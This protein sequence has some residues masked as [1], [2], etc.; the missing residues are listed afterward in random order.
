MTT[1][2]YLREAIESA[3]R[4]PSPSGVPVG[5]RT[6]PE[7]CYVCAHCVGRI[8]DLGCYLPTPA[9]PIWA[10]DVDR[11]GTCVMCKSNEQGG[12]VRPTHIEPRI[13]VSPFKLP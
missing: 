10:E 12:E 5:W 11:I 4:I 9:W 7:E 2:V 3:S 1:M 13:V 8:L 6:G